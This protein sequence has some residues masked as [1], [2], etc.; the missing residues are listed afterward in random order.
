MYVGILSLTLPTKQRIL[1]SNINKPKLMKSA[2]CAFL[3]MV[4]MLLAC[5]T[6]T[7]SFTGECVQVK[8]V[9][10]ICG[11]AVFKIQDPAY[12]HFGEDVD[13]EQNVFLGT[14]KCP[15]LRASVTEQD[16]SEKTLY[17]E[18]NPENFGQDCVRCY[19]LVSYSGSKS[20]TV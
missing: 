17:V 6:A 11:T 12:Y 9:R 15:H 3:F 10:G 7:P 16:I 8:V 5:D 14:L 1:V 20:Y 18:L 4:L 13:G 2:Y 19:A